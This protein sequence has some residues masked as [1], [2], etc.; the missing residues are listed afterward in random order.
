M[1]MRDNCID[2]VTLSETWLNDSVS[3]VEVFPDSSDLI[4]IRR[5]IN[6]RGGCVAIVLSNNVRLRFC[7]DFCF[8]T[9]NSGLVG[10]SSISS[11]VVKLWFPTVYFMGQPCK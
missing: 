10:F 1:F 5:D 3:D 2:C 9:I 8:S 11:I 6:R 7:S 4:V